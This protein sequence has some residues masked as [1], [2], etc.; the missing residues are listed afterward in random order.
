M[1]KA[2]V[3]QRSADEEAAIERR[4]CCRSRDA[5]LDEMA[6]N[7]CLAEHILL[8]GRW[9]CCSKRELHDKAL[10]CHGRRRRARR[11]CVGVLS[12]RAAAVPVAVR[13]TNSVQRLRRGEKSGVAFVFLSKGSHWPCKEQLIQRLRMDCNSRHGGNSDSNALEMGV[14]WGSAR[15]VWQGCNREDA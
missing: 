10:E 11:S 3:G 9:Q 7:R 1:L 15:G 8:Q 2:E 6:C 4:F 14:A 13:V 12:S 5:T